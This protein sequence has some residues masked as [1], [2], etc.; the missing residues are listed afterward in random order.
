MVQGNGSCGKPGLVARSSW[1]EGVNGLGKG[2]GLKP[3]LVAHGSRAEGVNGPGKG[4]VSSLGS[5]L[6]APRWKV[7]L[8]RGRVGSQARAR[9]SR[10]P[11]GRWYW[12][13]E[14]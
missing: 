6:A 14:G 3:R 5:W 13:G 1:A 2:R 7:V 11:G 9:G 8:G 12:A 10:L 4:R